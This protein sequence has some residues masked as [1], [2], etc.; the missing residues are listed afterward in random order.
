MSPK[1]WVPSGGLGVSL[2][3][4][5]LEPA[6]TRRV[7]RRAD[8]LGYC[9]IFVDGRASITPDRAARH[10]EPGATRTAEGFDGLE[11]ARVGSI[12]LPSLWDARELAGSLVAQRESGRGRPV[13]FFGVGDAVR[14][15]GEL[16]PGARVRWLDQELSRLRDELR[17]RDALVPLIVAARGPRAMRVVDRHADLWDANVAP[18][19]A[20]LDRARAHLARRVETCLWIF[21]R[22]NRSWDEAGRAY[23]RASPWFADLSPA[24]ARNAVLW[25]ETPRCRDRLKALRN[26]LEIDLPV[27][28]L[29]GLEEPDCLAALE[30]LAPANPREMA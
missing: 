30:A 7:A 3:G 4:H 15:A 11:R 25:G 5:W 10:G 23:R 1:V 19:R 12:Q 16:A 20:R 24:E 18:P 14:T 22:P 29:A 6:A 21:A 17:G 13:G 26:E 2:I 8:A 28:D 27:L 9:L